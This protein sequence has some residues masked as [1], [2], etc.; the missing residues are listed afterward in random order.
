MLYCAAEVIYIPSPFYFYS[1]G[2]LSRG[3]H[4]VDNPKSYLGLDVG[5]KKMD[6][7]RRIVKT[8]TGATV[9]SFKGCAEFPYNTAVSCD[10]VKS[11]EFLLSM[12][13]FFI[14]YLLRWSSRKNMARQTKTTL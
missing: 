10:Q 4:A 5:G 1:H 2:A 8:K 12:N 13:L 14:S 6:W 7:T 9:P 3:K 11:L